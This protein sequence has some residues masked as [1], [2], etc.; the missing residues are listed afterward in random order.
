MKSKGFTLVEMLIVIGVLAVL[1]TVVVTV[2]NPIEFL[3]KGRDSRRM[4]DLQ[5]LNKALA[6]A[7]FDNIS[8]GTSSVVYVSIPDTSATCANLGLPALPGG[9][10]YNCS[11]EANYRKPD[12]TGWV[13]VNFSSLTTV[14]N[15]LN[16]LP[17][18]P[19][20][21]T[22]TGLY[23][24]YVKGSWELTALL[25]ATSYQTKYASLDNGASIISYEIGNQ[26]KIT[27]GV[28]ATRGWALTCNALSGWHWYT[29]NG[30]S[31]CW[32]KTLADSVSWNK[33]VGNN[34]RVTG[35]YT[36]AS[37]E[38]YDLQTRMTAAAAGEWY[39]IVSAVNG[40]TIT[41]SHNG[42]SGWSSISALAISD[43]VHG[44]KDLVNC[45]GACTD[46]ST[47][48]TWLRNWAG[49]SGKSAL[50]YLATNAGTSQTDNDYWD[51]CTQ[52]S[53]Y[54]TPLNSTN[55]FYLNRKV[56]DDGDANFSWVAACGSSGGSYWDTYAR[57]IDKAS[58]GQQGYNST[59]N[60]SDNYSFRVVVRP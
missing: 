14:P 35:T 33:G 32:S 45:G 56:S 60:T 13:P 8:T 25:E 39:K 43:C 37:L 49:A 47:T 28:V 53:G 54:D 11:T 21:T 40:V 31:A 15:P 3:K 52:N 30:R 22:S 1:V 41:S 10:S 12:G 18:D 26:L 5:S 51:A 17:I 42:S 50:P 23:Y 48:N 59:S 19:T 6:F 58:C 46:W 57:S 27:P 9:W 2:L 7:R 20:N 4:I 29:T 44:T 16:I 38:T 24:T 34:S 36:C 55:N